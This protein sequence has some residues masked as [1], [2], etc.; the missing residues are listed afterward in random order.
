MKRTLTDFFCKPPKVTNNG[1][2]DSDHVV[3]VDSPAEK[4]A[5]SFRREWLKDFEWLR[6]ENGSM[7]CIHCK[8]CGTEFAGNTAFAT[9]STHFKRESLVKHGESAKHKK[10]RDKCV[11]KTSVSS[12]SIVKA[13]NRQ[14]TA[15]RSAQLA[16]L[17][18]K[19]NTAYTIAKEELAFTKFKPMLQLMKKN[20]IA[21]N[22]TYANDKSCAN[23]IGVIADTIREN[24]AVK[25]SSAQYISFMIDGDT[26]LSVKECV[27]VY[28]RILLD[29]QPTTIL[30]GH[31]EVEHANA[32]G[33]YAA[34]KSAFAGLGDSCHNWMQKT[35]AMGANGAAVNL[36]KKGGVSVKLQEEAGKHIIPFHCMPHRLEL[37]LLSAQKDS[38][39]IKE[40]MED[41]SF[42]AFCHFLA[43]LFSAI[44]KYSLLLQRNDVIL[45]QAVSSLR[46]LIL[47]VEAMAV[48][49]CPGGKL[50]SFHAAMKTQRDAREQEQEMQPQFMF[51]GVPLRKGEAENMAKDGP[52]SQTA[53]RLQKQIETTVAAIVKQLHLRF[54]SLLCQEEHGM[55]TSVTKAVKCFHVFNHDV[56]PETAE[57]LVD[58]GIEE[59]TFLLDHFQYVLERNGCDCA[60]A[61]EEFQ[62][63][64][65]LVF[66]SFKDKSYHR[67]WEVLLTKEPYSSDLQNILHLVKIMLVLPVSSAQCE[68]GFS[69]QKRIKSDIR[70]SL[71]PNS[72]EDLIR[73]SVEGPPL[74]AFD[75]SASVKRWMSEGQRAKRP[76]F[77][78]WPQDM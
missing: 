52:I 75:A 21:I 41:G 61:M 65:T 4:K 33:I 55:D 3:N 25:V 13:F 40:T 22:M 29:G 63:L 43:D 37:A 18:V 26:D 2:G 7:H 66:M 53:P 6:Y 49:P 38:P 54:S 60:L 24:T 23:I 46:N 51:R 70:S 48:R 74:E 67:L 59:V 34:S 11:A 47:N 73:I 39:W 78:S 5:Y 28:V 69:I 9:E 50:A 71:H 36:G 27:I 77:K 64:K 72:V 17:N 68:R 30:I 45:P 42:L 12:G 16:E 56:W 10:C 1:A 14:D 20:G 57:E 15:S 19:F 8:T 32:D 31:V 35:V 44:S 62:T 58:Y 76:N